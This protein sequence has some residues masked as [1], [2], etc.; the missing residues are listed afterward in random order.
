MP[1]FRSLRTLLPL[2]FLVAAVVALRRGWLQ[3][4]GEGPIKV[5]QAQTVFQS[6]EGG[7]SRHIVAVGDLHGDYGNALKV[8]QM[9]DVVDA[10]GNWTGN[11]DMFVQTGDIIDR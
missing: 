4:V 1:R 2:L 3:Q 10:Q 6:E 7:Y 5:Q 11:I 8:L 9:A